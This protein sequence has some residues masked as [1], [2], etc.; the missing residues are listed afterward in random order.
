MPRGSNICRVDA[1]QKEIVKVVRDMGVSVQVLSQVGHGC[2]DTLWG[3]NGCN[4][5]VE[6]KDGKKPLS[7]QKL[8]KDEQD[9]FDKW[10][11]NVSIVRS[12]EDAIALVNRVRLK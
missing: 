4:L 3:I 10:K 5:L 1:N 9:F 8:T 6:I 2:P 12:V 11:G 7:D